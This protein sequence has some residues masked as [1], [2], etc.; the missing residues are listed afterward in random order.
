MMSIHLIYNYIDVVTKS[1]YHFYGGSQLLFDNMIRRCGCS[2]IAAA[3]VILYIRGRRKP[4]ELDDYKAYVEKLSPAF[5]YIP[6]KGIPGFVL[7]M[8][9]NVYFRICR[10]NY[11]A[12]FGGL[13]PLSACVNSLGLSLSNKKCVRDRSCKCI[14]AIQH[15]REALAA[16]LPVILCIGPGV[17][18]SFSPRELRGLMLYDIYDDAAQVS[19][20][21]DSKLKTA[22]AP[23]SADKHGTS[24]MPCFRTNHDYI[25]ADKSGCTAQ[26]RTGSLMPVKRVRSHF[27]V[28]TAIDEANDLLTVSSWGTRYYIRLSELCRYSAYDMCGLYTNIICLDRKHR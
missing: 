3:D 17:H 14:S 15:I 27:V 16:D 23:Y 12:H 2:L 13:S 11:H 28:I 21:D 4:I 19:T 26:N 18:Q 24:D 6:Y 20:A 8:Y 22:Q 1:G 7:S 5:P 9:L 10:L 25:A